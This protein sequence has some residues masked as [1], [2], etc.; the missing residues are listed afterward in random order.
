MKYV[1]VGP[2]G[3][4]IQVMPEAPAEGTVPDMFTVQEVEDAVAEQIM[5]GT[6]ASV[7]PIL[8][9]GRLTT[10]QEKMQRRKDQIA[11][12]RA[13][14]QLELEDPDYN[15]DPLR[16]VMLKKQY[17]AQKRKQAVNAGITVGSVFVRTDPQSRNALTSAHTLAAADPERTFD[18]KMQDGSFVTLGSN[19]IRQFATAVADHLQAQFTKERQLAE[20]VDA[21]TNEEEWNA[22]PGWD[23]D[24]DS[25]T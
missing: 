2:R 13:K 6:A 24:T 5:Q 10:I 16:A 1:I 17:F 18:W 11:A 15:A 4:P 21:V 9:E 19:Q 7:S 22:L 25:D 20:A 3:K 23:D 14:Q 12:R 8:E